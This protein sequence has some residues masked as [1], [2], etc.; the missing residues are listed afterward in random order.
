LKSNGWLAAANMVTSSLVEGFVCSTRCLGTFSFPEGKS[1]VPGTVSLLPWFW[2]RETSQAALHT[3][4][5]SAHSA[6]RQSLCQT[7]LHR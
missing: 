7:I 4:A 2:G 6:V 5:L 3:G 1:A